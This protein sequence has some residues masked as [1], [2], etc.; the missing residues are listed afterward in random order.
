ME[1]RERGK[2]TVKASSPPK[3][4]HQLPHRGLESHKTLLP[5][6]NIGIPRNQPEEEQGLFRT[7]RPGS[8]HLGHHSGGQ[9]TDG[10]HTYSAIQLPIQQKT[11]TRGLEGYGLSSSAPPTPQR[12]LLMENGQQEVQPTITLARPWSK[13][14]E[15]M[16][17]R[18]IPHR[19]YGNPQR[20]ESQQSVKTPEE[21][22]N[23]DKCQLESMLKQ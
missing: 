2:G 15:D 6:K 7:R 16:S 11:Q 20:M 13:L 17:Q 12:F 10:N 3:R 14:S 18:D 5:Y 23:Q 4:R 1:T 8:G 19:S 21:K 22:G 9:D